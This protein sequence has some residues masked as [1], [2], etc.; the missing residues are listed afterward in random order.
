MVRSRVNTE[1]GSEVEAAIEKAFAAIAEV[2]PLDKEGENPPL[3]ISASQLFLAAPKERLAEVSVLE[4]KVVGSGLNVSASSHRKSSNAWVDRG[5]SL[6]PR[7][8]DVV[9]V[10]SAR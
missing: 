2:Q 4:R 7:D 6:D 3:A 8:P 1:G 5:S 9:R 10:K